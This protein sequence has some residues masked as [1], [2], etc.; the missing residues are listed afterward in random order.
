MEQQQKKLGNQRSN[1]IVGEGGGGGFLLKDSSRQETVTTK[2]NLIKTTGLSVN[3]RPAS[4]SHQYTAVLSEMSSPKMGVL[5]P[6]ELMTQALSRQG[7]S[8]S[9]AFNRASLDSDGMLSG[10]ISS[11]KKV[12]FHLSSSGDK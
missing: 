9:I 6:R 7:S 11:V 1:G 12:G 8:S 10:K 4:T 3:L 5:L 2:P